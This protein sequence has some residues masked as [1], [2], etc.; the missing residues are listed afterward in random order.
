MECFIQNCETQRNT[1][2]VIVNFRKW[3]L[4]CLFKDA[5]LNRPLLNSENPISEKMLYNLTANTKV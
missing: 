1:E 3:L 2:E 5:Y 4:M